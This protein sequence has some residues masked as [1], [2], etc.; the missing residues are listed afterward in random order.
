MINSTYSEMNFHYPG[1]NAFNVLLV[2]AQLNDEF[3]KHKNAFSIHDN[4]QVL[5]EQ[6]RVILN[7]CPFNM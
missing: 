3:I 1:H 6:I 4:N 5:M 7:M 2:E